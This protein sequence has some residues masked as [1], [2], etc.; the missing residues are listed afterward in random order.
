MKVIFL[1]DVKNV[2][3]C[4]DVK[5]VADG[6]ARNFLLPNKLA[7]LVTPAAL[8]KLEALKAEAR[9]SEKEFA[10]RVEKIVGELKEKTLEFSLKADESGKTF[11]SVNK[12]A[13]LKALRDSGL[14]TKERVEIKLEHPIKELGEHKIPIRFKNGKETE[15][16]IVVRPEQ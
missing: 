13:V 16:K 14:I 9:Q 12:D 10:E 3:K 4:H 8:K 11:G 15:L 1:Q 2:A 6:Y 5:D 7:E